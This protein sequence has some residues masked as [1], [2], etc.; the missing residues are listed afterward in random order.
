MS[1]PSYVEH[2]QGTVTR[3]GLRLLR[4]GDP[5]D[6]TGLTLRAGIEKDDSTAAAAFVSFALTGHGTDGT[7][8]GAIPASGV[9]FTGAATMRVWA[10]GTPRTFIG[11]PVPVRVRALSSNWMA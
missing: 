4:D 5:I 9:S 11:P 7:L 3:F 1:I 2:L 6:L 10:S 8:S